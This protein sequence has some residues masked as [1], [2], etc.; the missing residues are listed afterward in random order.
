MTGAELLDAFDEWVPSEVVR[1]LNPVW[2]SGASLARATREGR[3]PQGRKLV[4]AVSAVYAKS[5]VVKWLRER[6]EREARLLEE[7]RS[8][9]AHARAVRAE[10]R[11]QGIPEKRKARPRRRA[12]S[13]RTDAGRG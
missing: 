5:E 9:A 13:G 12:E 1:R 11:A 8:R 6:D 2:N 7:R 4:S 3:G 10:R